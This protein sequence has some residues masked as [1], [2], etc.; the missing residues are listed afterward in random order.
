[1]ANAT[2]NYETTLQKHL[3]TLPKESYV[4]IDFEKELF[5]LYGLFDYFIH[6]PIDPSVEAFGQVYVEALASGVPS[7]FTLSGIAN[8]FIINEK[9]AMVVPFH[10]TQS[11]YESLIQLSENKELKQKIIVQGREEVINKFSLTHSL[12]KMYQ[13]Y[14]S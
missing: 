11:I 13:L 9:N 14:E 3:D 7:I 8:E 2:G 1:M 4:K 12:N 6:V 5:S 10:D